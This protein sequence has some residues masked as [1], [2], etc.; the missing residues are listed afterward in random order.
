M[1]K[2]ILHL[3]P[4]ARRRTLKNKQQ[5]TSSLGN[6]HQRHRNRSEPNRTS[7]LRNV[8]CVYVDSADNEITN[9]IDCDV[10][11]LRL[12]AIHQVGHFYHSHQQFF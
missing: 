10:K 9:N 6:R 11:A 2:L 5:T 8:N 3:S 7:S 1:E 12:Y 4:V